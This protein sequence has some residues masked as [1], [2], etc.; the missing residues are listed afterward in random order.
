VW[1]GQ[2]LN[3]ACIALTVCRSVLRAAAHDKASQRKL[4]ARY[5]SL[6][7]YYGNLD[8]SDRWAMRLN[9]A[10][11]VSLNKRMSHTFTLLAELHLVYPASAMEISERLTGPSYQNLTTASLTGGL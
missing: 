3:P 7:Q 1:I 10:L 8:I 11:L 2:E 6:G 9:Y 4:L 5:T